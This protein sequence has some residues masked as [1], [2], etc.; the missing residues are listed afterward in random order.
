MEIETNDSISVIEAIKAAFEGEVDFNLN[1]SENI[2][3]LNTCGLTADL[4]KEELYL[5][6]EELSE[7]ADGMTE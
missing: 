7:I 6:I 5:F 4:N 2:F 3:T 1:D